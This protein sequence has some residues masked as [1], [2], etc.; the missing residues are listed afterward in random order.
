MLPL[1]PSPSRLP[2]AVENLRFCPWCDQLA[3]KDL[4][5]CPTC[6]RRMGRWV[7]TAGRLSSA[8]R[9]R[10]RWRLLRALL[11]LGAAAAARQLSDA[12]PKSTP[13]ITPPTDTSAEKAAAQTTSTSTTTRTKTST[14]TESGEESLRA[15]N[16]KAKRRHESLQWIRRRSGAAG[17]ASAGGKEKAH[18]RNRLRQRRR[19]QPHRRRQRPVARSAGPPGGARSG[20]ARRA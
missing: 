17:G 10:S 20:A 19:L 3:Q 4:N 15:A 5:D 13:D 7:S 16:P 8:A 14:T 9:A 11:A 2:W 1:A 12:V 6:G 18:Q